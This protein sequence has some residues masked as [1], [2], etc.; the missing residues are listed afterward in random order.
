MS[1]ILIL[2]VPSAS[3]A[4][5][6]PNP[7]DS[8][9]QNQERKRLEYRDDGGGGGANFVPQ[10][11]KH[12]ARAQLLLLKSVAGQLSLLDG[13]SRNSGMSLASADEALRSQL[14][15]PKDEGL[16]VASVDIGS[17]AALAGIQLNDVL[18]HLGDPHPKGVA[19][20]RPEDLEKGL[21][22]FT[23]ETPL[24]LLRGGRRVTIMIQPHV[25]V[26]LGPLQPNPPLFWIGVSDAPVEPALVSQLQLE[27]RLGLIALD[28]VKESAAAK[29][30]VRLH[31]ILLKLDGESLTD[32]E[33]LIQ[34]VQAK[35]E[36]TIP[37]VLIREG[38]TLTLEIT[39][40]RR[41]SMSMG[42]SIEEKTKTFS[43]SFVHPGGILVNQADY[44]TSHAGVLDTVIRS[45]NTQDALST[46][47]L[48]SSVESPSKPSEQTSEETVR[49]LDKLSAQI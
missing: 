35:G 31:D 3:N 30:G 45:Q 29:A 12:D 27:P 7:P 37:L 38:K 36:K 18:L 40:Q 34:I 42:G 25:Q 13:G 5:Q 23:G 41:S 2:C 19:L 4:Q 48:L 39:P 33:T 44:L 11:G 22:L 32:Q 9:A 17:A 1:L 21:K 10:G 26:S 16:L 6:V 24:T 15:L 20:G 8:P 49:R 46:L 43:Y 14:K 28:I 47:K